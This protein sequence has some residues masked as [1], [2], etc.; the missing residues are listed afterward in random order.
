LK[1]DQPEIFIQYKVSIRLGIFLP[2]TFADADL[3]AG[4]EM[5][6]TPCW[7]RH[8]RRPWVILAIPKCSDSGPFCEKP[9]SR[10]NPLLRNSCGV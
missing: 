6:P 9:M 2:E 10:R 3:A 4:G 7:V 5:Q 1:L 8:L